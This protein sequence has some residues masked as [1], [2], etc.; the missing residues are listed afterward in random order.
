MSQLELAPAK[1]NLCLFLGGTRDD[2]RHEL[3]TLFESISLFDQLEL[4][5]LPDGPD[6]VV[7]P[8]VEG[9]NLVQA[10]L[11]ELRSRG[12]SAPAVRIQIGKRIPVAAGLGGGSADAAAALRLA[13]ELEPVSD[14]VLADIAGGMG[15]DVPSQLRPG[16]ALG[17][18]AGEV[19]ARCP[20]LPGHAFLIIPLPV[21]LSTPDV[22]READRLGLPRSPGELE[23][24]RSRLD[25]ALRDGG[26]PEDSLLVNDLEPAALSL[27]PQ[28]AETLAAARDT[29]ADQVVVSGSGP[30]VAGVYW[31][32]DAT[33]RADRAAAE[34]AERFSGSVAAQPISSWPCGTI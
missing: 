7:C 6:E 20:Q 2:G 30:T 27:C 10:A 31:G 29:G 32:D 9:P 23:K 25:G 24:L 13:T 14:D 33:A 15:A 11:A 19:V 17:T 12:W 34:L 4:T 22:Y 21:R 28:V 8:G 1:V 3:V 26:R 18:G 5:E 16:V